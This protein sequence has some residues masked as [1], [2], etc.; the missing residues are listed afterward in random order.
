MEFDITNSNR[1]KIR[2]LI[3][4]IANLLEGL[5]AIIALLTIP[6]DP[7]NA[8]LGRYSL[9]RLIIFGTTLAIFALG[10]FLIFNSRKII[11][12]LN[13]WFEKQN[14]IHIIK[15]LGA[16]AGLCL[17]ITIWLPAER[18]T[19]YAA[20]FIRIKPLLLWLELIGFQ[21]YLYTKLSTGD[22]KH[23]ECSG[24][25]AFLKTPTFAFIPLLLLWI[26]I[27][28]TKV[29]LVQ[30]TA[31][32]NVPGIPLGTIQFVGILLFVFLGLIFSPGNDASQSSKRIFSVLI[33]LGIYV[34]AVLIWGFT[35]MLKHFFSLQP[36]PP[37]MQPYPYS[38]ARI[39]DLGA[40][41]IVMGKG[42]FFH[43]STD[44]PL[45][46]L[47]LAILHIFTGND[48]NLL[49]WAQIM[50]LSLAPVILY[51]FGKKYFGTLFG[52]IAATTL[53]LQQ[54]N[55]IVLSYKVASVNPKLL[56]SEEPMLLGIVLMTYLL[57]Q[58][59]NF[60]ESKKVFLLGG[61]IGALSLV[62]INPIFI[63]PLIAL[64]IL[65]KF[66]KTPKLLTKQ[67]IVF[68]LG[69]ILVFSPW[70]FTGVNS[71]GK[72]WFFLKIQGVIQNRYPN[73]VEV[74]P[75]QI[76]AVTYASFS[77]Q[78]TSSTRNANFPGSFNLE[79]EQSPSALINKNLDALS[80]V[81]FNHFLHNFSTSFLALPDSITLYSLGDLTSREYWQDAN[82]WNGNF[83]VGQ[84]L[85]ILVNLF[86]FSGGISYS[87]KKYHWA[88]L[89][90]LIVFLG[91]DLSLG[92]AVNSGSRYIVP[93]NWII[94]FYYVLG[95][96]LLGRFVLDLSGVKTPKESM[97]FAETKPLLSKT[98]FKSWLPA[99]ITLVILAVSLP[100]ANLAVPKFVH[101]DGNA[102]QLLDYAR[103]KEPA[104]NQLINGKI[105]YPYYQEDG[106]IS[107]AFLNGTQVIS[108][109]ISQKYLV[110]HD[111]IVL[112]SGIPALLSVTNRDAES[113]IK[114]IY[115]LEQNT[116][117]LFWQVH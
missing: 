51:L 15:W 105:L 91:Y 27:S 29:G 83:P 107:F 108:Y 12:L 60:P 59:M 116:P 78:I 79:T 98:T 48:Y 84:Y 68:T 57:F 49:Q 62:R 5:G 37:N 96:I 26:I 50:V 46:M 24:I 65:I 102:A 53:V 22:F 8:I 28:T 35:P 30:D 7:K 40:L 44:K 58:W 19:I 39:Y 38:D 13:K 101:S 9:S 77:P 2:L 10:I 55:A 42:I 88:G 54:R 64:I 76:P 33:P 21:F 103:L 95:L 109:S 115:L 87:W 63:A 86:I 3:F 66:W 47:L 32:W 69:F 18:L 85:L 74:T 45:Y 11:N 23:P 99:L 4:T 94:F 80:W 20:M 16:V 117:L 17:W 52:V 43:G 56:V 25:I 89:A 31:Y 73:L 34:T 71:E 97:E 81:M 67:I 112:E 1:R 61:L 41:S 14:I 90:P 36:T 70:L 75:S 104:E 110:S 100:I 72:S 82:H 113:E 106:S 6:S 114:S 92:A 111:Q 93:I